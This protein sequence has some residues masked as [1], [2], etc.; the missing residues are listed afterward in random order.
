MKFEIGKGGMIVVVAGLLGLSGGVFALG[1]VAGY[2][3]AKQNQAELNEVSTAYPLPSAPGAEKAVA[4]SHAEAIAPSAAAPIAKASPAAVA[5]AKPVVHVSP[6]ARIAA[7]V[8]P[9]KP[10]LIPSASLRVNSAEGSPAAA[11]PPSLPP[12]P[13]PEAE[14]APPTEASRPPNAAAAAAPPTPR[15]YNIQIE[16]VMDKTGAKAMVARL[17]SLGYHAHPVTTQ[18]GGETWY[19]VQVGPYQTET[20][21]RDAQAKLREQY[22]EHFTSTQ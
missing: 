2:E 3:M 1:L 11:S 16:A 22:K 15:P 12:P 18:L 14:S 10:A 13:E 17:K 20:E 8:A 19:R 21:A 7:A 4:P 5:A 6:A 9:P